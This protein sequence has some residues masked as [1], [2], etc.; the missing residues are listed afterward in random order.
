MII[1]TLDRESAFPFSGD[2]FILSSYSDRVLGCCY[3][4][5]FKLSIHSLK[6]FY[7][8]LFCQCF[9]R[10]RE[11]TVKKADTVPTFRH[12]LVRHVSQEE[13]DICDKLILLSRGGGGAYRKSGSS[14][15]GKNEHL[16]TI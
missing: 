2:N 13:D 3:I 12:L 11:N 10:C 5:S 4:N 7:V 9:A 8:P 15:K 1:I 14:L 16:E 6:Y